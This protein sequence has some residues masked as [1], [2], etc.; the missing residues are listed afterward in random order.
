MQWNLP[1]TYHT[2]HTLSIHFTHF[3]YITYIYHTYTHLLHTV[4]SMYPLTHTVNFI[5][6][7]IHSYSHRC[8]SHLVTHSQCFPPPIYLLMCSHCLPCYEIYYRQHCVFYGTCFDERNEYFVWID[9]IFYAGG[10]RIQLPQA[11]L[12]Q[13]AGVLQANDVFVHIG[14]IDKLVS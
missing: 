10:L 11:S 13:V 2:L 3:P 7:L 9:N 8:Y 5:S 1:F 6:M 12:V 4:S 14:E